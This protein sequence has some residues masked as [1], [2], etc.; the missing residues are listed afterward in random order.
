LGGVYLLWPESTQDSA[1]NPFETKEI[2]GHGDTIRY[3]IDMLR[4]ARN[5]ISISPK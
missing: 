1:P 2:L 3:E 4:F 5:E